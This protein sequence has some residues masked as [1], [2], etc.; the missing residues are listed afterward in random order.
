MTPPLT[1]V[2]SS[3]VMI[4]CMNSQTWRKAT[5]SSKLLTLHWCPVG[6]DTDLVP[7]RSSGETGLRTVSVEDSL[8]VLPSPQCVLVWIWAS[9]PLPSV[10]VSRIVEW[11]PLLVDHVLTSSPLMS[12]SEWQGAEVTLVD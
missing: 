8:L 6:M 4:L 10:H 5:H 2:R 3:I 11:H 9:D 12:P 1:P 7:A